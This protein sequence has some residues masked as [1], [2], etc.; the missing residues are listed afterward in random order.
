MEKEYQILESWLKRVEGQINSD[1]SLYAYGTANKGLEEAK[2]IVNKFSEEIQAMGKVDK[3]NELIT[4]AETEKSLVDKN[5]SKADM[6]G[7]VVS[8]FNL[9][10]YI[11]NL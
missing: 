7:F 5:I 8:V 4:E 1:D 6:N 10:E 11:L 3:L 9:I 2:L